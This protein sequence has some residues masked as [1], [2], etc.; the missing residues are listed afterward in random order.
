MWTS[1]NSKPGKR[2][3]LS[4]ERS[5]NSTR[6]SQ[7]LWQPLAD[8]SIGLERMVELSPHGLVFCPT[9][10]IHQWYAEPSS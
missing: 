5:E 10:S 9:E 2:W 1:T 4:L 7:E 8:S 3:S 6:E